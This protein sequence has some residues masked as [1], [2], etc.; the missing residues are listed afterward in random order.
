MQYRKITSDIINIEYL[1]T[2]N[3]QKNETFCIL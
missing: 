2:R 3:W 1:T